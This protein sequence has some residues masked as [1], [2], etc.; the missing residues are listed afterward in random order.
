MVLI[1]RGVMKDCK[2]L[3]EVYQSSHSMDNIIT[4]EQVKAIHRNPL[5]GRNGWLVAEFK[6]AVVGEITFRTENHLQFGKT[7]I[8]MSHHIDAR[9]S[10]EIVG[11]ELVCEAEKI[12]GSQGVKQIFHISPPE[13]YNYWMSNK[14]F[15]KGNLLR[16]ESDLSRLPK[17]RAKNLS[18][19][20][21]SVDDGIPR[22]M[23]FSNF[24]YPG[25]ITDL[26]AELKA[27]KMKGR[28]LEYY[29][30]TRLLGVGVVIRRFGNAAQF[31]AD[32]TKY[33]IHLID[34][35]I[36]K[37]AR[38]ASRWRCTKVFSIVQNGQL[39]V[40]REIED[41]E[42]SQERDIPVMRVL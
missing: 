25:A 42:E 3:L 14:Y 36:V 33:G 13:D 20:E 8:I 40:F 41:W 10:R 4:V 24:S 5:I 6:G 1:R 37:T 35:I 29:R 2:D 11:P 9:E 19:V 32:V 26:I 23:K 17:A 31:A 15:A 21:H 34:A 39:E 22:K 27:S 12:M 30:D 38:A 7:G 18:V 28:L 16:M